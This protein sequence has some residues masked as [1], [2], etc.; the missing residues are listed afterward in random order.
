MAGYTWD[1]LGLVIYG[2]LWDWLYLGHFM[3]GYT[4][5]TLGLVI[6]GILD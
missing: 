6:P 2:I 1:T 3:A 4:W 5:D